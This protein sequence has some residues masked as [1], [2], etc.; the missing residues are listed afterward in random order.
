MVEIVGAKLSAELVRRIW[1]SAGLLL[2]IQIPNCL[3]EFS[4]RLYEKE[5][6]GVEFGR[7]RIQRIRS[8]AARNLTQLRRLFVKEEPTPSAS[9]AFRC[10]P[11]VAKLPTSFIFLT[12]E[13]F[14]IVIRILHPAHVLLQAGHD[15]REQQQTRL[16]AHNEAVCPHWLLLCL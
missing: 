2:A 15:I 13:A 12:F 1:T 5:I 7:F 4:S 11:S 14:L 10:G 6:L 9:S 3:S 16:L 8:A